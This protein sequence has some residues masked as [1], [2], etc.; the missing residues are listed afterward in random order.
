MSGAVVAF[1]F[2]R[3]GSKGLPGKNLRLLGGVTLVERAIA[4]AMAAT[5]V[6]RVVLSTDDEAIARVGEAAGAEVP[7]LRPAELAAD[8]APEIEAWR[9]ALDHLEAAGTEVQLFVSVPA[10]APLRAVEDVDRCIA[11]ALEPG[12]DAAI[13]VT[14]TER[15]PWF[16]MVRVDEA[17][18]VHR[19]LDG[20]LLHRRQDAP[21]AYA[22]TPVCYAAKPRWVRTTPGTLAGAIVGV[23]VPSERSVD[24]DSELDLR[25]AEVLLESSA[26]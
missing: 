6:D 7:F 22:V 1:V 9:H 5:A 14:R 26:R 24:I 17:G 16:D 2:C 18:R 25:L 10:T 11:A 8:D 13:T 4:T 20:P 3:G 21:P 15:N 23:E 19:L 12:V